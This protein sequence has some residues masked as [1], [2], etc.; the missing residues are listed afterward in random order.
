MMI[1]MT[2]R[3][4]REPFVPTRDDIAA[5]PDTYRRCPPCRAGDALAGYDA[6]AVPETSGVVA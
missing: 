6:R 5:G 1:E 4:C 2:C 3:V